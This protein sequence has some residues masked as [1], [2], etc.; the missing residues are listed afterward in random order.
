[1][2]KYK[3]PGGLGRKGDA[4]L[5]K[6]ALFP[7]RNLVAELDLVAHFLKAAALVRAALVLALLLREFL[8]LRAGQPLA[9]LLG[10]VAV[11]PHSDIDVASAALGCII[12]RDT[13]R[14]D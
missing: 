6:V 11:G 12:V 5:A 7:A 9:A 3:F 10:I 4:L 1:M 2:A 13:A 14:L 8:A